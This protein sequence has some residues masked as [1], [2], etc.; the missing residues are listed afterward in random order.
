MSQ[1]LACLYE[2]SVFVQ[3]AYLEGERLA[4]IASLREEQ[5]QKEIQKVLGFQ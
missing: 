1:T 2:C 4:E 3:F 5:K